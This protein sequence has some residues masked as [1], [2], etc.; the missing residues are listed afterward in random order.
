[1]LMAT[2]V[3]GGITVNLGIPIHSVAEVREICTNQ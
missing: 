3:S 2:I 1:M